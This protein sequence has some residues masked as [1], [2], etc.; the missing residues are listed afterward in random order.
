MRKKC[1]FHKKKGDECIFPVA[2]GLRIPK[3][4]FWREQT[5]RSE[6]LSG[7][8]HGEPGV[9]QPTESTDDVVR[10]RD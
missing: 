7:E 1:C 2:S 10:E 3:T 8:L 5:V 9:S 4:H 6:D